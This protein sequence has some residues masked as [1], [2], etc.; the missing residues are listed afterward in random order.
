MRTSLC[1]LALWLTLASSSAS[2][3]AEGDPA[4]G[5]ALSL[6]RAY[7]TR[8]LGSPGF[9]RVDLRLIT[10]GI[11]TRQFTIVNMW[12]Q[13][14]DEV[15]TLF[16]LEQPQGLRGTGYLLVERETASREMEVFLH[17]PAG[18][19]K[20]LAVAASRYEE[21]LLG[22]DFGYA[23]VR[24]RIPV[25]GFRIK[26]VGETVMLGRRAAIV[27]LETDSAPW[28]REDS[29]TRARFFLA[30]DPLV[31]LGADYFAPEENG[32][33]PERL[34]KRMRVEG[35]AQIDRLWT[36]TRIVM[37]RGDT[38]SSIL[39]LRGA[40]FGTMDSDPNM[41][42]PGALPRLADR[43]RAGWRADAPAERSH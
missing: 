30:H 39:E 4:A 13:D 1:I 7:N 42:F 40:R 43:L 32:K 33:S 38:R 25:K 22:S 3:P 10:D 31:L 12:R 5:G 35:L 29:W 37:S 34:V 27:D 6:V 15:R 41:F 18:E 14:G 19:H 11:T 28:S 21:G 9:R 36:A 20:V 16:L 24:M 2:R 8:D 26:G 17:L 23:D